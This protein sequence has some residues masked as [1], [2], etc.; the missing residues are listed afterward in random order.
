VRAFL[1]EE[2][3][4][5]PH[6]SSNV[7]AMPEPVNGEVA[8]FSAAAVR[9][10]HGLEAGRAVALRAQ[11]AKYRNFCFEQTVR[12]RRGTAARPSAPAEPATVAAGSGGGGGGGGQR[13][14]EVSPPTAPRH[15]MPNVLQASPRA[16]AR[17]TASR[18]SKRAA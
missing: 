7:A 6:G 18:C 8:L 13:R 9:A 2:S 17:C 16:S 5:A 1:A 15:R 10:R 11:P 12:R 3:G 4:A 14:R